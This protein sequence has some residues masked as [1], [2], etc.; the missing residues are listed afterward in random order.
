MVE[1]LASSEIAQSREAFEKAA[2]NLLH[3]KRDELEHDALGGYK[4]ADVEC[5]WRIWQ[6][7]ERD[8]RE[9]LYQ[10]LQSEASLYEINGRQCDASGNTIGGFG[11]VNAA[12][13]LK[14]MAERIRGKE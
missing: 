5:M 1:K 3:P 12:I 2:N 9:R 14:R 7:A 11:D 4:W 13:A 6:A 8:T 10:L